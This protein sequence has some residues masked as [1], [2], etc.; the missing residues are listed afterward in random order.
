[1]DW[2]PPHPT[3]SSELQTCPDCLHNHTIEIGTHELDS[4]I[5]QLYKRN[6]MHSH[7][8]ILPTLSTRQHGKYSGLKRQQRLW[9][10]RLVIQYMSTEAYRHA[11]F[12]WNFILFDYHAPSSRH[13]A[14]NVTTSVKFH[15]YSANGFKT[16]LINDHDIQLRSKS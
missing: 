15:N 14:E 1:M 10:P 2:N 3:E 4:M 9:F 8:Q 5:R 13:Y 6:V 12:N 11:H 7:I 16:A